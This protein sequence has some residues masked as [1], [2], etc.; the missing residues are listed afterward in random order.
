M[1]VVP[2]LRGQ[3]LTRPDWPILR[4]DFIESGVS[5]L[6]C[7]AKEPVEIEMIGRSEYRSSHR[8]RRWHGVVPECRS[9]SRTRFELKLQQSPFSDD[10]VPKVW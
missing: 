9:P 6:F 10:E 5:C 4:V 1:E 3:T 7:R 2:L 8:T